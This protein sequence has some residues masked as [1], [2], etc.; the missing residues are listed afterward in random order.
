MEVM[1]HSQQDCFSPS[2]SPSSSIDQL[3]RKLI[4]SYFLL[5]LWVLK[6]AEIEKIEG[7]M[8][9]GLGEVST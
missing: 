3:V 9:P 5:A 8:Q 6:L 1:V 7:L 4:A 2:V